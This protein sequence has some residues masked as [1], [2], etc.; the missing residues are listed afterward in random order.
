M[1]TRPAMSKWVLGSAGIGV[2]AIG[3]IYLAAPEILLDVYGI[4]IRSSSEANL[5]KAAY[6]GL[7]LAFGS[8]FLLGAVRVAYAEPAKI[9]LL[10]FMSGLAVGRLVSLVADG[11]PHVLIMVVHG[12]E[13]VYAVAAAYI[14]RGSSSREE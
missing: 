5:F 13:V 7:F 3:V 12:V 2:V 11:R 6:G 14:L 10:I 4:E 1:F 8:L 9:A